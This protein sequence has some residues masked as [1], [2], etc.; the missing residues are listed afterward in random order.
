MKIGDRVGIGR[1][2]AHFPLL[3][4]ADCRVLRDRIIPQLDCTASRYAHT[5]PGD[6]RAKRHRA[7]NRITTRRYRTRI[8]VDTSG[9]RVDGHALQL[10][11][12]PAT[13]GFG[14]A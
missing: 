2:V 8:E 6:F 3:G 9:H 12:F 13:T 11:P 10:R 7:E 4:R 1:R 14:S 5:Q